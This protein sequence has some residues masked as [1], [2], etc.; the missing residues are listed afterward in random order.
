MVYK[1]EPGGPYTIR[2]GAAGGFL[3]VDSFSGLVVDF[4]PTEARAR[5]LREEWKTHG[6]RIVKG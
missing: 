2:R 6:Y 5:E 4:A 1:Q 3:V